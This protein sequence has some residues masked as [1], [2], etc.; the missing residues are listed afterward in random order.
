LRGSDGACT[1]AV[2]ENRTELER[3]GLNQ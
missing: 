2:L 3:E 1:E